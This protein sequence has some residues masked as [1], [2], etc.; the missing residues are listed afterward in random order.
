MSEKKPHVK[1]SNSNEDFVKFS[2]KTRFI[3][4]TIPVPEEEEKPKDYRR[5][6]QR[7][8]ASST[9]Y[10]SD[11]ELRISSRTMQV[12]VHIEYIDIRFHN[13]FDLRAFGKQFL[14]AFGLDTIKLTEFNRRVLF[15][16]V[17][18]NKFR[19]FF[20]Q[21]KLFIEFGKGNT[22]VKFD[23]RITFIDDFTFLSSKIIKQFKTINKVVRFSLLEGLYDFNL[24]NQVENSLDSF[25]KEQ[26]LNYFFDRLNNTIEIVDIN[27]ELINNIVDNFDVVYSVTSSLSTVISPSSVKLPTRS[28][29]FSI[30]NAD[31]ELPI[32]GVI[33]TGIDSRTPLSGIIVGSIDKTGTNPTED[34]VNHGT[35]VAALCS[36]GKQPYPLNYRGNINADAKLLSLKVL[37]TSTGALLDKTVLDIIREAKTNFPSTKI[38]VLTINYD[39][40][41]KFNEPTNDYAFQLD[42]LSYE[43]GILIFISTANNYNASNDCNEYDI[44]YF[45]DEKAN[46]CSPAESM[47]NLTIGA[48]ADN[49]MDETFIGI[50]DLKEFPT[51]YSRTNHIEQSRIIAKRKINRHI[52]KPDFIQPGGDYEISMGFIGT[53]DNAT[54]SVLSSDP[55]ESFYKN[56]GTSFSAPLAA[57]IA[58]KILKQYP[59]LESQSIKALL[60]N[61][62]SSK[63]IISDNDNKNFALDK[64]IGYGLPDETKAVFSDLNSVTFILE[65]EINHKELIVIPIKMPEYLRDV[66]KNK[67]ILKFSATLCFSF[68]P[69][70]DNHLVY[71]PIFMTFSIFRNKTPEQIKTTYSKESKLRNTWTQDGYALKNPPLYSNVQKMNF[72]V[73][74]DDI[75]EEDGTFKIAVHCFISPNIKAGSSELKKR[76]ASVNKFSLAITIE[77]NQPANKLSNLLYNQIIAA[78][79]IDSIGTLDGIAE[80]E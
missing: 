73:S 68:L 46:L 6:A 24:T 10:F 42:K 61:S 22:E 37:N 65:R 62:C 50:S 75:I 67:A 36:L 66:S 18:V 48:C 78:N 58:A 59:A 69:D 43:L 7:F 2:Y 40:H 44:L 39:D 70:K 53:G 30:S 56:V 15:S 26:Q 8:E 17:D 29:G 1:L 38:F 28:Y 57:N 5:M 3:P 23:N 35:A 19:Y 52:K 49:L 14:T 74:K 41:K 64:A 21:I 55:T 77:E 45:N 79:T 20:E 13:Q 54:M 80:L 71:C 31:E 47:N 25:L 34:I 76:I 63:L 11:R 72:T 60:I 27:E 4:P 9:R 51:L 32:I 33:D 16:I 12:P